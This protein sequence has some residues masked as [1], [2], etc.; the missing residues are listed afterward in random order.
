MLAV[1]QAAIERHMPVMGV[2]LG[3]QAIGA[4]LGARVTHAPRQMHGKTSQIHHDGTG[5]FAGLPSPLTATRY[6]SL[7]LEPATIPGALRVNA[8]S[9]E[10]VVQGIAH[11]ERPIYGVQFHP[12][13]V[14]SE[15]GDRIV[16]NFLG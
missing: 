9:E 14:L 13:S 4:V 10:G 5:L 2:C 6:H 15:Y 8:R 11:R 1:L 12:E 3:L 16:A 7:A